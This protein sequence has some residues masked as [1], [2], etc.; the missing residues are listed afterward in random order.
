[1]SVKIKTKKTEMCFISLSSWNYCAFLSAQCCLLCC[2]K[3]VVK[4]CE[5]CLCFCCWLFFECC[6]WQPYCSL[7]FVQR[8]AGQIQKNH[9][10]DQIGCTV[11]SV[12]ESMEEHK[13]PYISHS[14][15]HITNKYTHIHTTETVWR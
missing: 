8:H 15:V 9:Y 4:F 2:F 1:M 5:M 14:A 6:V 12:M 10:G 13:I 11:G 7:R 3:N